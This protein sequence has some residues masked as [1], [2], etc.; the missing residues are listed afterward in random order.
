[1]IYTA[2]NPRQIGLGSVAV[3]IYNATNAAQGIAILSIAATDTALTLW[4]DWSDRTFADIRPEVVSIIESLAYLV[5]YAAAMAWGFSR[6][7]C[8]RTWDAWLEAA[9]SRVLAAKVMGWCWDDARRAF[10]VVASVLAVTVVAVGLAGGYVLGNAP[11]WLG[12]VIAI[13]L[14][15]E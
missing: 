12:R 6:L 4:Q 14:C 9:P 10:A 15:V 11:R 13:A 7:A 8:T 5:G 1:M 3:A 2:F